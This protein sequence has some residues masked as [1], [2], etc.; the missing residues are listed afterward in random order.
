MTTSVS[1][2]D[3]ASS[4]LSF[5]ES[6]SYPESDAIATSD[7]STGIPALLEVVSKAEEALKVLLL[8]HC[9]SI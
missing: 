1:D 8:L 5:V 3:V 7:L 6:G 4:I 9:E 2:K